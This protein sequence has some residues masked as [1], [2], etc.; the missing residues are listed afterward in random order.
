MRLVKQHNRLCATQATLGCAHVDS[1]VAVCS[2]GGCSGHTLHSGWIG[3]QSGGTRLAH[4]RGTGLNEWT[5]PLG[6]TQT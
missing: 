6:E 4:S 3:R 2:S 5:L 1:W